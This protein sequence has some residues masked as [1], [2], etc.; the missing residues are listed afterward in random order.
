MDDLSPLTISNST[1]KNPSVLF[2]ASRERYLMQEYI[3][4]TNHINSDIYC[5][6]YE[7]FKVDVFKRGIFTLKGKKYL[8]GQEIEGSL[9]FNDWISFQ[10]ENKRKFNRFLSPKSLFEMYLVDLFFPVFSPAEKWVIPG[11]KDRFMIHPFPKLNGSQLIFN[12]RNTSAIGMLDPSIISFFR[13]VKNE[14]PTV[15]EEFLALHHDK[16]RADLKY[17]ISL[18]PDIRNGY[19]NAYQQCFEPSFINYTKA[20]IENYILQL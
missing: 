20:D 16:F 9:V 13:Y 1:R 10:W 7:H 2:T 17:R 4:A 11:V 18:Y 5:F 8:C 3:T 12:S 19:W 15:L 6:V 14:L